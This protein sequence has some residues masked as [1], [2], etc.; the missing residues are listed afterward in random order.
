MKVKCKSS[1]TTVLPTKQRNY[2]FTQNDQ[3]VVDLT[4]GREYEVYGLRANQEG[5]FYLVL[6]DTIH[7]NLPWWMPE[8]FFD[9]TE[10]E[11]PSLWIQREWGKINKD[12]ITSSPQYFDA[13]D[14]IED[15][16]EKGHQVF[17]K[18]K[19]ELA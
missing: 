1:S 4:P 14:D 19:Q 6:T 9:N 13:I 2:A 16:T 8:G 17:E 7:N 5:K 12:R 15:G 11:I 3:G 10:E 18:M